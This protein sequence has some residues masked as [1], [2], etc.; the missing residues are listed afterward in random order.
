MGLPADGTKGV[1]GR[2]G[3]ENAVLEGLG[4]RVAR[5]RGWST[6]GESMSK[7]Q[8]SGP[9]ACDSL[10]SLALAWVLPED[11]GPSVLKLFFFSVPSP[12]KICLTKRSQAASTSMVSQPCGSSSN[13]GRT[14]SSSTTGT[15]PAP[16]ATRS[17]SKVR[18]VGGARCRGRAPSFR[19]VPV[20]GE[21]LFSSL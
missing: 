5:G 1:G 6:F 7:V 14:S 8:A 4:L 13:S 20:P 3:T 15:T 10:E 16:L 21:P 19:S 18:A 12:P 17:C 9:Q 2:L 11:S